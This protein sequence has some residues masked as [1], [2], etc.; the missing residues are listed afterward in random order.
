MIHLFGRTVS[1]FKLSV[2]QASCVFN[3]FLLP[4]L[5]LGLRYISGPLV[6]RLGFSVRCFPHR[7][8]QTCN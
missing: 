3:T 1:K 8:Y 6:K 2:G 5:E 7:Q 4:K